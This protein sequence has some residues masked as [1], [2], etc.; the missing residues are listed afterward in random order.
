MKMFE[1]ESEEI[2]NKIKNG[3]I[4]SLIELDGKLDEIVRKKLSR[5]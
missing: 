3:E 4:S 5:E 2:Y 1:Q